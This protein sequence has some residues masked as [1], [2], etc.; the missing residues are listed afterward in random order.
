MG[1]IKQGYIYLFKLSSGETSWEMEKIMSMVTNVI[2]PP[3]HPHLGYEEINAGL[4]SI[5]LPN[6]NDKP[7]L[8]IAEDQTRPNH[9]VC[10]MLLEHLIGRRGIENITLVV[11]NGLHRVPSRDELIKKFGS[12]VQWVKTFFNNPMCN[13]DW[14]KELHSE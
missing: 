7:I 10:T 8:L 5:S 14:L 13:R 1:R 2:C 9:Q 6:D 12:S 3:E 4:G 11:G